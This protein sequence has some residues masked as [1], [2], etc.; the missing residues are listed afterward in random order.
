[1]QV[2]GKK[3]KR[4]AD[5]LLYPSSSRDLSEKRGAHF[6][7][8]FEMKDSTSAAP[9]IPH[10]H[11]CLFVTLT[12]ASVTEKSDRD[13]DCVFDEDFEERSED[14]IDLRDSKRR[15]SRSEE[16][17]AGRRTMSRKTSSKDGI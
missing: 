16:T 17:E 11:V 13:E 5:G 14:W 15:L 9:E 8:A 7:K 2:L 4:K 1:M 12:V 10:A 6:R 3:E